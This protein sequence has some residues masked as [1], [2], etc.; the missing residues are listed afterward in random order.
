MATSKQKSGVDRLVRTTV[1]IPQ[2]LLTAAKHRAIDKGET[3]QEVLTQAL[4]AYVR[5]GS[6]R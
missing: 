1:R 2:S 6:Q 4:R 5:K 3:L